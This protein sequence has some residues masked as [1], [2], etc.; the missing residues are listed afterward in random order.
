MNNDRVIN[1]S[2]LLLT[3]LVYGDENVVQRDDFI[4]LSNSQIFKTLELLVNDHTL[5]KQ[6]KDYIIQNWWRILYRQKPPACIN[7]FLTEEWVG[8]VSKDIYPHVRKD[9][10]DFF[11]LEDP[12][13]NMYLASAIGG[14]KSFTSAIAVLYILVNLTLMRD[15]KKY[16]GVSVATAIVAVLGSFTKSK[17]KQ[18]LLAP[19]FNILKS[20]PKFRNVRMSERINIIQDEEYKNGTDKIIWTTASRIDG[21]IEFYHD[22]HI[23]RVSDVANLLGMSIITGVLSELSF[24]LDKG[25]S[26][27][28]IQRFKEDLRGRIDSR[29]RNN[30]W[31][32]MF[33]D[34]SPNDMEE[35][36]IDRYIFSGEAYKNPHDLVINRTHWDMYPDRYVEWQ[37]TGETFPVFKGNGSRPPKVLDEE[38]ASQYITSD[39]IKVPIDLMKMFSEKDLVKVIKDYAAWPAGSDTKIINN[40]KL[41]EKIF[42]PNLKNV[43]DAITAPAEKDPKHLIWDQ[44][45]DKFFIEVAPGRWEFYRASKEFRVLSVDQSETGDITSICMDHLELDE[46]GEKVAVNDFNIPIKANKGRINVEATAEFILDLARIGNIKFLAISFDQYQSSANKQKIERELGIKVINSLADRD[47]NVYYLY[48]S[49]MKNDKIKVGNS[50]FLKNN[51]KSLQEIKTDSGKRKVDHT[52][53]KCINNKIADVNWKTDQRGINAKDLSDTHSMN[54]Y[55]LSSLYRGVPRYQWVEHDFDKE[56]YLKDRSLINLMNKYRLQL[57]ETS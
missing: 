46:K 48:V 23:L 45:R 8:P 16:I 10:N 21:D 27:D 19:F 28:T 32:K 38:S 50:I 7:D 44:I 57:K 2:K 30:Y 14:G 54:I 15:P 47:K 26:A 4:K 29:F 49:W 25:V 52:K 20:S 1:N 35:S 34:S 12:Y 33:I 3:D 55:N 13:Y 31:G 11:R 6:S 22:I 24:F 9:L 56:D 43:Y 41:I 42:Y 18:L 17:A 53:G 40:K 5:T 37:K 39:I 51:L 36:P